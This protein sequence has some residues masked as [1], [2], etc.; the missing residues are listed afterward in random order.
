MGDFNIHVNDLNDQD[1]IFLIEAMSS[2]GFTQLVKVATHNSGN[3]IDLIFTEEESSVGNT[4][5]LDFISDHRW[6][7]CDLK[8]PRITD[9]KR[10]VTVRTRGDDFENAFAQQFCDKEISAKL[11]L[12]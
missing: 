7:L 5:V 6:V 12:K 9:K 1:A 4:R 11:Y 8:I 10:K 2:L 3:T